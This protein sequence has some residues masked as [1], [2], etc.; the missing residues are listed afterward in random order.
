MQR[1]C[2]SAV[3]PC[4]L[5]PCILQPCVWQCRGCTAM[6]SRVGK[7]C[8]VCSYHARRALLQLAYEDYM[9]TMEGSHTCEPSSGSAACLQC[10]CGAATH[11]A[12][13]VPFAPMPPCSKLTSLNI[14]GQLLRG[15]IPPAWSNQTAFSSLEWVALHNNSLSGEC[16]G[17]PRCAV[18]LVGAVSGLNQ[19]TVWPYPS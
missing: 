15:T 14:G 19:R 5:Q 6:H 16:H 12:W 13:N 1:A 18:P 3:Q 7:P 2:G 4:V 11:V 9:R 10:P 17:Q 8:I